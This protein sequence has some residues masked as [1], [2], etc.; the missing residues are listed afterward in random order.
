MNNSGVVTS[1]RRFSAA[2]E[3]Y[4]NFSDVQSRVAVRLMD[5]SNAEI[6]H[7]NPTQILEIGCGTGVLTRLLRETYPAIHLLAIDLSLDM[8]RAA[9]KRTS[10]SPDTMGWI[11][12]DAGHLPV[13]DTFDAVFSSSVLHWADSPRFAMGE[14]GRVLNPG[15]RA[16]LAIMTMGTLAEL[17]SVRRRIAPDNLPPSDLPAPD[18]LCKAA[19]E[20]GLTIRV[21]APGEI[22]II[23]PSARAFLTALHDQGLTGGRFSTSGRPLTRT[24]LRNL[25]EV[26][27]RDY[28]VTSGVYATYRILWL[29]AEK[30]AVLPM[31]AS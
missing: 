11:V 24:Q 15:G 31:V 10:S 26:Y 1:N 23:Y 8:I 22:V 30:T 13:R 21:E 2:A 14:I 20:A 4:E 18:L 29:I 25:I 28:S 3:T 6:P 5:L 19:R 27:D 17:H 9:R 12:G 16:S 7:S